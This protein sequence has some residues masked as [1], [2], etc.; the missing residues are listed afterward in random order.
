MQNDRQKIGATLDSAHAEPTLLTAEIRREA[1]PPQ[2]SSAPAAAVELAHTSFTQD[3][4][5]S[6]MERPKPQPGVN[7]ER[8]RQLRLALGAKPR[9]GGR[10]VIPSTRDVFLHTREPG[11]TVL[12]RFVTWLALVLRALDRRLFNRPQTPKIRPHPPADLERAR[13][14]KEEAEAKAKRAALALRLRQS[15]E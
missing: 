2:R 3:D 4:R 14:E 9:P 15:R 12:D 11:S 1:T 5:R 7:A 10:S 6:G 13:R 8:I